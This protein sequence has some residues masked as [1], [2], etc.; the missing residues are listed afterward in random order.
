MNVQCYIKAII[1]LLAI[2]L[3]F[4]S[5][6]IVYAAD[7]VLDSYVSGKGASY[8][9]TDI[10]PSDEAADPSAQGQSFKFVTGAEKYK[11]KKT[12]FYL[13]VQGSPTGTLKV[14]LYAHTGTFGSGGKPTGSPLAVSGAWTISF[15]L[16]RSKTVY[17]Y[18]SSPYFELEKNTAYC[19]DVVMYSGSCDGSNYVKVFGD[20]S[21]GS[22][23]QG[24]KN[25]F[26]NGVWFAASQD[27]EFCVWGEEVPSGEWHNVVSWDFNLRTRQWTSVSNWLFDL[28]SPFDFPIGPI[29]FRVAIFVT[30]NG[31]PMDKI[32]IT[33]SG[34]PSNL[35]FWKMTDSFGEAIVKLKGGTYLFYISHDSYL[36]QHNISIIKNCE[37]HF[38]LSSPEYRMVRD[39]TTEI[40][41]ITGATSCLIVVIGIY[42]YHRQKEVSKQWR[43]IKSLKGKPKKE[44]Q[45]LKGKR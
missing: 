25:K 6:N 37:L 18:F 32:N 43:K 29:L 5:V 26:D 38:E 28:A 34:G 4:P 45:K 31:E 27:V 9:L 7:V 39:W 11:L 44:I 22:S 10:H 24:N 3:L 19:I 12:S 15:S 36:V 40:I 42:S 16:G 1:S 41:Q 30:L 20:T 35:S 14:Y 23:H 8:I 2:A 17:F 13:G 21:G 33:V